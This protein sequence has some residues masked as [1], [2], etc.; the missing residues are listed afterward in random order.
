MY[1]VGPRP[2]P[3]MILRVMKQN[4]DKLSPN[5]TCCDLS[6]RKLIIQLKAKCGNLSLLSLLD[7]T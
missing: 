5:L 4:D 1:G 6:D 3:C 2:E 7:N